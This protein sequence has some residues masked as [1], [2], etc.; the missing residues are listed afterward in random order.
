MNP[1]VALT[2]EQLHTPC[3]AESLGFTTTEDLPEHDVALLHPRAHAALRLGLDIAAPGYSIF[4]LGE[5]GSGRHAMVD[6]LLAA[7]R[8][9]G[10]AP[11]DWCYVLDFANP[12]H[13]RLLQLPCGRGARL[14]DDMQDFVAEIGAAVAAAFESDQY[15]ERVE[16]LQEEEKRREEMALRQLGDEV[17]QQGVALL[18]TPRGFVFAPLKNGEETLSQEEFA[19]LPEARQAE[20]GEKISAAYER[21]HKLMNEFPRWRREVQKAIKAVGSEV[22]GLAVGHLI[23]EIKPRYADLPAVDHYLDE[24]LQDIVATGQSLREST[25]SEE[26]AEITSYTGTISVQRYLV[27]LLV[28]NAGTGERPVIHENNPTLQNLLGRIEHQVHMGTL[29]SNFTLIKPGALHRANG[30][31]LILDARRLLSQPY[32]WEGL[33]R[34]LRT[35]E[36]RVE[37]L[38]ELLGWSSTVQLEPEPLPLDLKVILI[39]ERMIHELLS[40]LDPD[41][42]ALFKISA[43]LDSEIRRTPDSDALY[44]R[45]IGSLARQAGL[46]PLAAPAVARLI[47]EAA[48]LADDAERLSTQ[49]RRL[50]DL[51]HEAG[52]LAAQA[53][54]PSIERSHVEA[55]WQARHLRHARLAERYREEI[56]RGQL[57][58]D[59]SGGQVGQI[60]GL[61]VIAQGEESC[62]HPMRITATVRLG[63]GEIIDIEREVELGGPIHS[64]GV[65][66]LSAFLGARYGHSSPLSLRA[67]LVFEQSYGG[68]DGDSASMAELAVLLSALAGVPIS[69]ALAVTGSVNQFGMVQPIGAVNEKIEGFFDICDAR[70]LTGEQGVI[71]PAAN[72]CHLMLHERVRAAVAAGRFHVWAVHAIDEALSLLTGLAAGEANSRGEWPEGTLNHAVAKRLAQLTRIREGEEEAH[73][74]HL[75]RRGKPRSGGRK[76]SR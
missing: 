64:K 43:D 27:N 47:E 19:E 50:S 60:N 67:T 65:L 46:R 11:S 57:L 8:T 62:A 21:M 40:E 74:A 38:A 36:I 10:P 76:R 3:R 59:T 28:E 26:D 58:I 22:L 44:A 24:V 5:P 4:L 53:A 30:G 23:E 52:H 17:Q 54:S 72:V 71:I 29:V 69:Q 32:A 25:K 55:A 42:S 13:A 12:A 39:G 9:L 15:R 31:F 66:I 16:S 14:R 51:M 48:R 20:Y 6:R 45:L 75:V 63:D 34:A 18:R 68:V 61:A 33:K 7:E 1:P 56:L 73:A 35:R 37:S 70:G 41:F 49:T 2:V